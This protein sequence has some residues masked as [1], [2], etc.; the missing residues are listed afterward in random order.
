MA[1][2]RIGGVCYLK[3]DGTQYALRGS[4]TVSPDATERE[5]Q[6]GLDGVHGFIEKPR[7]P[8]VEGEISDGGTLSLAALRAI[9]AATV[10]AEMATGKVYVLSQAWVAGANEISGDDG[11]FK[12]RFEGMACHEMLA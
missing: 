9:E 5:G 10:T 4:F 11:K 3:V 12:V 1:T 6:A 7:V 8:S 2:N